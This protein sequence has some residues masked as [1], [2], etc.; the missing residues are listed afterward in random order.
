MA[1]ART[2][3]QS[4]IDEGL[5]VLAAGGPEA[6]RVEVLAK[7]LGVTKGGFYGYFDDRNELLDA[8]LDSWES[9]AADDVL[10]QIEQEGGDLQ[11]QAVRARDLTFSETLFPIELAIRDWSRRD[12]QVAAYLRRVDAT[13]IGLLRKVFASKHS[14]PVEVE[15]RSTLAFYAS[16]G[17]HYVTINHDDMN[18]EEVD[19]R[20]A[21]LVLGQ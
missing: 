18:E 8:M 6:V 1:K 11:S 20:I 14:D 9:Q 5:R 4:W 19:A 2:P 7:N 12:D 10:A 3:R 16:I 13:R 21:T 17:A 15:A